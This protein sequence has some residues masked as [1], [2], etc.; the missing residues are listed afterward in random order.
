VNGAPL[1]AGAGV[2]LRSLREDDLRPMAALA[3][4][5]NV[6]R[7][8]LDVFPSP[9]SLADARAF[10]ARLAG[11]LGPS[12]AFAITLDD[13]FVGMS[14]F[15]P[16]SDVHRYGASIGYWLGEPYWG[17]GIATRALKTLTAYAFATFS[18]ERLQA[19]VFAWN[20][21][22]A[23]VLEKA[24]YTLE[25]RTRRSIVKAGH[26]TDGLLYARLRGDAALS[27]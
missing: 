8:L 2:T 25:G 7:N 17:R 21:A 12:R 27:S 24:G 15:E 5:R 13:H 1:L 9:Y 10:Y 3:D 18:I 14:G 23:R 16:L 11:D 4:N 19:E 6:W 20:P 22:S 26:I